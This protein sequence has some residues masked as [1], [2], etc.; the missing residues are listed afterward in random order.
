M[1]SLTVLVVGLGK[2]GM[3]Y[4][5]NSNKNN[6][7]HCN[8]FYNSKFFSL[9]A[10]V[11]TSKKKR[12]FFEKKYKLPSYQNLKS[13]IKN[14]KYD[15]IVISVNTNKVKKVY[16]A[17]YK[18]KILPKFFVIEKPGCYNFKNLLKLQ[19]YCTNNNV[20]PIMNYTR[21]Y[22]N[23]LN[24]ISSYLSSKNIGK[25]NKIE[26]IYKKG[27]FNS[28]SHY[29]SFIGKILNKKKEFKVIKKNVFRKKN[30][31]YGDFEI[32]R[33]L[34]INFLYKNSSNECIK[35][36]G[37]KI[38]INYLTEKNKIQII[39]KNKIKEIPND[40][41]NELKNLT[42][43]IKKTYKNKKKINFLDNEILTLK[44]LN[45]ICPRIKNLY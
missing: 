32:W 3:M 35:I 6:L 25:I 9:K 38:T 21:N 5:N 29:I 34:K 8:V 41:D 2:I 43:F 19:K 22:S 10:G 27:I 11:D 14:F 1:K 39:L 36:F 17:I 42:N 40:F 28:C 7:N 13:A 4:G 16:E 20:I 15:I 24:K 37:S 33:N 18:L 45:K 12:N 31:F 23:K 30:D 44:L 26:V